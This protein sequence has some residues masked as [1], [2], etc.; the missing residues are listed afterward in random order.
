LVLIPFFTLAA[1]SAFQLFKHILWPDITIWA[2]HI[3][4]AIFIT[5]VVTVGGFVGCRYLETR[6]LL[7]YIVE[8]SGDAI[9]GVTL[10]GI[11]LSWNR[12]A[13]HIY[14]YR[15][16][17]VVGKPASIL[18][19]SDRLEDISNILDRIRRGERVDRYETTRIRKDGK[20]VHVSLI[21]SPIFDAAGRIIGAS[22]IARDITERKEAEDALRESEARLE[23]SQA[24]S[25]VM[26][27]HIGLDGRWIK[28]P[29][30]LCK[31]LG[32]SEAEMLARTSEDVTHPEDRD[33][34]RKLCGELIDGRIKSVDLEKRCITK[35]GRVLPIYLNYSIVTDIEGNPVHF[36]VY[37][38]DITKRRMAEEELKQTNAYLENVF[39]N[40]PD[41]ICIVDEHGKFIKWN[42]MAAE[43]YGYSFEELRGKSGFDLYADRGEMERMLRDLRR[44]GSVKKREMLMKRKDGGVAP[45]EISIGLLQDGKG[46]VLGSVSVGRD[47]SEIKNALIELKASNERLSKEIIVRKRAE[48][49]VQ[50]LSRQKQLILDAAGEGIVGLDLA[51]RVAFI[52]PAG[53][54][55]AGYQVKELIQKDFHQ[56][57]HHSRPDGAP[58]PVGECP[59]FESLSTGVTRRERD[60]VF[61]RKDGTSFP[62]AYSSTPIFEEGQI[63]GAVLTF[64]DITLRKLAL[65]QLKEYRDHL[66]DLVKERTMELA[67]A[68][69]RL[70]R[71]IEERKRAEDALKVFAYSVVHD[72]KSPAIG[73]Y[74]IT[75]RLHKQS[76]DVLD[77]K[78]RTYCEQI[79]KVSEHIAALVEKINVYIVTKEA[80]PLFEKINIKEILTM[81]KDEFS[82]Q[83]NI[84]RIEWLE[85]ESDIEI[86]ADR[87]SI[88]RVFRNL[89]DNALK[90]GGER[91][92]NIWIGH[93]E[94]EGFHIVSITDNGKGLKGM[95]AEKIFGLFQ[96]HE[97]SRG[98]EGAGL[99]LAIV[100][101]IAQQH[102]GQVW[103]EPA[104]KRGTTF[105][106]SISKNL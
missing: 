84:R 51:G 100:K 97:T 54:E 87:L 94:T 21:V 36:L 47:L 17:E 104:A 73:I 37:I 18:L 86:K 103:V 48:E 22:S 34:E 101:E 42:K 69:E 50:W 32:Y 55:L 14:G 83:L 80:S 6:S 27:A 92:S 64:R 30:K 45:S 46:R 82:A 9:F 49:E 23:R 58:Y 3:D 99:G 11:I 77:E 57:V 106:I 53:A 102:G 25:L 43:L 19:P 26:T 68:N 72:L 75:K 78:G 93:E 79:L 95:D 40:S 71:E 16:G 20:I 31:L 59:M 39:E 56:V 29:Q 96:R 76:K 52:N 35:D 13:E 81:L 28:A 91:L 62:V 24:F 98:V 89:V 8:S 61:W 7:A 74:G 65:E 44:Q 105:C 38:R 67:T 15:A 4:T 70:T 2:S 5:A 12:G 33:E 90:Y 85:P 88:L 10:D 1:L 66:E 60:E 41:A 63:L